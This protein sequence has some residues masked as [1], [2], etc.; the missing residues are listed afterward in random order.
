MLAAVCA[1]PGPA[2]LGRGLYDG[3]VPL[4]PYHWAHPP[5]ELARDNQLPEPGA[6]TLDL[7]ASGK[8]PGS[9]ATGDGQC[10]VIFNDGSVAAGGADTVLAVT[11]T[12]LDPA[13][14][15][16]PPSG[17]RFDGNACRFRAVYGRDGPLA[18]FVRPVTVVLRY[19]SYG[20]EIVQTGGTG[21]H[22]WVPIPT[23]RYAGHLHLLVA[24]TS[25]LGVFAPVAPA[26]APYRE[27]TPWTAYAVAAAFVIFALLLLVRRRTV[28]LQR[29]GR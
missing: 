22:A 29:D 7:D 8:S 3:I 14:I 15:A 16:P 18:R 24:N 4:P 13:A 17:R 5:R 6:S 9:A 1:L 2:R 27:E 20:T 23:T 12:P 25:A 28:K 11:I 10:T 26:S 21:Q 19:A